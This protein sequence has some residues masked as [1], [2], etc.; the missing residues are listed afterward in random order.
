M[1]EDRKRRLAV[2]LGLLL[3]F[4]GL[5]AIVTSWEPGSALAKARVFAV[6]A[7]LLGFIFIWYGAARKGSTVDHRKK[8]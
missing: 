2:F 4:V 6:V 1:G 5:L 8:R 3:G 7:F